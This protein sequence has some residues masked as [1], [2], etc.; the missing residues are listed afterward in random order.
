MRQAGPVTLFLS[1]AHEDEPFCQELKK[2]LRLLERQSLISAWY[3]RQ[4]IAGTNWAEEIDKQLERASII[5]LLISADFLASDYCYSQE[6]TRALQRHAAG[7]ARVIPLLVR[8]CDWK[9]APFAHLQGLPTDAHPISTWPDR[10]E[11]WTN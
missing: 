4:I 8:P 11:A 7:E 9:G 6:M 10:D 5:L 3:D 2:H 1:Y